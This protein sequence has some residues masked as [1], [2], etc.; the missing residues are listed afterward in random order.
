MSVETEIS[1]IER[2]VSHI[3]ELTYSV[4]VAETF[5]HLAVVDEHK[6][7]VYPVVDGLMSLQRLVLRYFVFVMDGYGVYAAVWISK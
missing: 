1:V 2:A 7:A 5:G 3:F 6:L 4:Y